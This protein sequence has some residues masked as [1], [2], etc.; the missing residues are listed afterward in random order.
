[1]SSRECG[2]HTFGRNG[3]AGRTDHLQML[4]IIPPMTPF[5]PEA[6]SG[7]HAATLTAVQRSMG[8]AYSAICSWSSLPPALASR[9]PGDVRWARAGA[10]SNMAPARNGGGA[11]ASLSTKPAPP[12]KRRF[13]SSL[14]RRA[15][16][17]L[18]GVT[19]R[20]YEFKH[21][22]R[23]GPE[24]RAARLSRRVPTRLPYTGKGRLGSC[25]GVSRVPVAS[26]GRSVRGIATDIH[27]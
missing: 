14:T 16:L 2:P 13:E 19:A 5:T 8:A 20:V 9:R 10:A 15:V 23:A 24:P 7:S 18:L 6:S 4:S 3:T 12:V 27:S 11:Q 21:V 17:S 22:A 26:G 25:A 1:M